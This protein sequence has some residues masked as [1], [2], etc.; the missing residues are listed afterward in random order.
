MTTINIFLPDPLH[1]FIEERL[2]EGGYGTISEYFRELVSADQ[3]RRAEEK[4][5]AL[6]LE[7]LNSGPAK[8]LTKTALD[9][10]RQAVRMR[11]AERAVKGGETV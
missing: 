6:L 1:T 9:E 7:G 10:V 3:R 4:L 2:S 8:P 11:I 5:E